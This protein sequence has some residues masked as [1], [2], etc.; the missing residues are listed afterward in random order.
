MVQPTK[1]IHDMSGESRIRDDDSNNSL[2]RNSSG[3]EDHSLGW[4]RRN[5][6]PTAQKVHDPFRWIVLPGGGTDL[7]RV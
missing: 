3:S 2:R 7:A 4:A 6:V 1:T 5:T